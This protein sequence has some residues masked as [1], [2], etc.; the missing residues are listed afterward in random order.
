MR[1]LEESTVRW[2]SHRLRMAEVDALRG[3]RVLSGF[4]RVVRRQLEDRDHAISRQGLRYNPSDLFS[5]SLH[6]RVR[7][8]KPGAVRE[9]HAFEHGTAF[10]HS[11]YSD[12]RLP[13]LCVRKNIETVSSRMTARNVL[14]P[15]QLLVRTD[16]GLRR[17]N[18]DYGRDQQSEQ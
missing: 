3:G 13:C 6:D 12:R 10:K 9:P 17:R 7:Q 18:H 5:R 4:L 8:G 14:R 2:E 1:E 11:F 15:K 16:H